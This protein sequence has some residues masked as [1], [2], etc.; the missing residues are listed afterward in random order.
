VAFMPEPEPVNRRVA[1]DLIQI[2]GNR[3]EPHLGGYTS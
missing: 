3:A 2:D 1:R